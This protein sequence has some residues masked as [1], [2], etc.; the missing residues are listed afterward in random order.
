M[1]RGEEQHRGRCRI[2]GSR[3]SSEVTDR[4]PQPHGDIAA[5]RHAR[6]LGLART[7]VLSPRDPHRGWSFTRAPRSPQDQL[8][9]T[10]EWL[11]ILLAPLPHVGQAT[12]SS[13]SWLRRSSR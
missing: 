13:S 7:P 5:K 12:T 6:G 4:R 8:R 2:R 10:P 11:R 9:A 1:S 3:S